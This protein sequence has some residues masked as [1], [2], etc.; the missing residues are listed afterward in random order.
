MSLATLTVT[1]YMIVQGLA[2]SFWGSFSDV[3][4][5]RV[6]FIGTFLVYMIAN[7]ALGVSTNYAQLMV[8]RALQAAGSAATI[9]IG[10]MKRLSFP[11]LITNLLGA[12]VIGDITTSA[13]RGSL[14]G[15]FGGGKLPAQTMCTSKADIIQFAC[16][17]K[18]SDQYL[19]VS[20]L[21]TSDSG[22]SSG[23]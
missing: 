7:I 13:E 8:F 20:Y 12:G 18:E 14:I 16:W 4:G 2:P 9:S 17:D 11:D 23:S 3:L 21:N 6:I 1:V 19:V 10:K 15:I 5:R 22:P